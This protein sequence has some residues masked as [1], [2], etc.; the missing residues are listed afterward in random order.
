MKVKIAK[1]LFIM[2]K[3]IVKIWDK[4]I[5]QVQSCIG[6]QGAIKINLIKI[7]IHNHKITNKNLMG[8]LTMDCNKKI[9]L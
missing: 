3:I 8:I 1:R 7:R 6:D 5:I 4:I 9:L 2:N